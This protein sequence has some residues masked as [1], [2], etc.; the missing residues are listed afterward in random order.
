[1]GEVG[2]FAVHGVKEPP[3]A[4]IQRRNLASR[5]ATLRS[6]NS[7]E[8]YSNKPPLW[9]RGVHRSNVRLIGLPTRRPKGLTTSASLMREGRSV[10]TGESGFSLSS[11]RDRRRFGPRLSCHDSEAAKKSTK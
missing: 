1:V 3:S 4:P 8:P 2:L 11:Y 7:F 5:T 10:Q 6:H 9:P